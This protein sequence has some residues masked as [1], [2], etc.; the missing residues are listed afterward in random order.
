MHGRPSQ[1]HPGESVEAVEF[2]GWIYWQSREIRW[3]RIG[4]HDM[5]ENWY[6]SFSIVGERQKFFL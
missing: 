5:T 6:P 2:L 3:Q 4:D 1:L